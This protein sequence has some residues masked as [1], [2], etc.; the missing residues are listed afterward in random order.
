[1]GY[2]VTSPPIGL[3]LDELSV[4]IEEELARL[5]VELT[6]LDLAEFNVAPEQPFHL[7]QVFADG[8][9]WNPGSGRGVYYYDEGTTTWKF[10]A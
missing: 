1:M 8:T 2:V 10:I 6:R 3:S 7:Q 5:E 4:W 9:N